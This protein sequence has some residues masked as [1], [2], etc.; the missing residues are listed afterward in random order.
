[1]AETLRKTLAGPMPAKEAV[2]IAITI[3]DALAEDDAHYG[4]LSPDTV[5][6]DD[7]E[8]TLLD[9][10]KRGD[11]AKDTVRAFGAL[12]YEMLTATKPAADAEAPSTIAKA[13]PPGLD[14]FVMGCLAGD[15][16]DATAMLEALRA[17]DLSDAKAARVKKEREE[18]KK[19]LDEEKAKDARPVVPPPE[20][21]D[22]TPKTAGGKAASF[23]PIVALV[24]AVG[25]ILL[26]MKR[27]QSKIDAADGGAPQTQTGPAGRPNA[28]GLLALE[29]PKCSDAANVEVKAGREALRQS[30]NDAAEARFRAAA[31][32]DPTCAEA[33]LRIAMLAQTYEPEEAR[34]ELALAKQHASKLSARDKEMMAALEPSFAAESNLNEVRQRMKTLAAAT[35]SDDAEVLVEAAE[36]TPAD[37][38][39]AMSTARLATKIDP[40]YGDAWLSYAR[41]AQRQ[42]ELGSA[43][44]GLAKCMQ[45][46]PNDVDCLVER[47]ELM[48]RLGQC[49]ELLNVTS[50]QVEKVPAL[51]PR[52]SAAL[53]T[54]GESRSVVSDMLTPYFASLA[55]ARDFE[56]PLRTALLAV[57]YGDFAKAREEIDALGR[58]VEGRRDLISH[59]AYALARI[60]LLE[61]TGDEDGAKRFAEETAK[62]VPG[63]VRPGRVPRH[64]WGVRYLEPRLASLVP[65]MKDPLLEKWKRPVRGGDLDVLAAWA[66]GDGMLAANQHDAAEAIVR[67]PHLTKDHPSASPIADF[68]AGKTQ[69]LARRPAHAELW[70]KNAIARCDASEYPFEHVRAHEQLGE[71]YEYLRRPSEACTAYGDV[72]ARWGGAKESVTAKKAK[73]RMTV[74][75]CTAPGG[76]ETRDAGK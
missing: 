7:D 66:Y 41:A 34:A 20:G 53:A 37:P 42:W 13:T 43:E 63:W 39:Y 59:G 45:Y 33:H 52:V 22:A 23:L 62:K 60:A 16:A 17:I 49:S 73:E 47:A 51:R 5:E 29:A 71:V 3:A 74:L 69:L 9:A 6:I 31:K 72:V 11:T 28:K 27:E 26:Y 55:P 56:K 12:L 40:G 25:G 14:A 15:Y 57:L 46:A 30:G 64:A 70:L 38:M 35:H 68:I 48:S 24:V 18:T 2:P 10:A 36:H 19:R 8:V 61:E 1:M 44:E 65:S 32:A 4:A 54:K 21:G 75:K 50:A 76:P 67:L 58:L